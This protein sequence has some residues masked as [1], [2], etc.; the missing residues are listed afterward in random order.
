MTIQAQYWVHGVDRRPGECVLTLTDTAEI[1]QFVT[2]LFPDSVSDA[3]LTH[4]RRPRVETV[5][6][7]GA[8]FLTV[9]DH[10]LI[11]GVHGNRAR[12]SY[13]GHDGHGPEPVHLFSHGDFARP[14][15]DDFPPNSEV[16]LKTLTEALIEFLATA[17]RPTCL[18]WQPVPTAEFSRP[19][20]RVRPSNA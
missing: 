6:P 13:R 19:A 17:K 15:T 18:T 11:V 20:S 7:D 3:I 1:G 5:I 2:A 8:A 14:G 10:S 16:S 9:P 4:E 12:L